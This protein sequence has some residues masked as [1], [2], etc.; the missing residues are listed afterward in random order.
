MKSDFT[1]VKK[2]SRDSVHSIIDTQ[3]EQ[4]FDNLLALIS[5]L[6]NITKPFEKS[7]VKLLK[8]KRTCSDLCK[9]LPCEELIKYIKEKIHPFKFIAED[10]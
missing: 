1:T 8:S 9:K 2:S 5:G 6:M 7:Y 3:A 10:K 4:F